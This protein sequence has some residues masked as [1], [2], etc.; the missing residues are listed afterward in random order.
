MCLQNSRNDWLSRRKL[1]ANWKKPLDDER[2]WKGNIN[3]SCAPVMDHN[4][5]LEEM[6]KMVKQL[7]FAAELI[8]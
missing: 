4:I 7:G 3:H 1:S 5:P 8:S 2:R 6:C